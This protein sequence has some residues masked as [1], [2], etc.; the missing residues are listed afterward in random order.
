M[1]KRPKNHSQKP[2]KTNNFKKAIFL[3]KNKRTKKRDSQ[4]HNKDRK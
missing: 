2:V 1:T 4:Q 3:M